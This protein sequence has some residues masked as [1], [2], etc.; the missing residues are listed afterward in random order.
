MR[1][2]ELFTEEHLDEG[3]RKSLGAAVLGG[4]LLATPVGQLANDQIKNSGP[5]PRDV[6]VLAQTIWAEARSHG[7]EG[8]NAVGHVIKNRV[9]ADKGMFGHGLTGVVKKDKQFSCWNVGDPNRDRVKAMMDIETAIRNQESPVE[10]KDFNEWYAKFQQT[11]DF[12][13]YK[14]WRNAFKV[15]RDILDNRS[16]DPTNGA[17]YYHTTGVHPYW[18]DKMIPVGQVASHIFYQLPQKKLT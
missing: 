16:K 6:A 12:T 15:A 5:A 11:R 3:I 14:A 4:A 10:G 7:V 13:D 18:A 1:I 9:D 8:M 17:V 2:N